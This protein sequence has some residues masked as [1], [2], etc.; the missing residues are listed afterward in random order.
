[1][2]KIINF[3]KSLFPRKNERVNLVYPVSWETMDLADFKSVCEILSYSHGREE[4]LFLCF[5]KLAN[6]RPDNPAKYDPKA[7]KDK[8]P[9]I[10]GGKSYVISS[11]VIAEGCRQ[12]DFIL[13]STGL[14]PSPF[15]NVD[16]KIFG[17]SFEKFFKTDS[18][19]MAAMVEKNAARLKEASKCLTGGRVRKL[20]PWQRKAM[21]IWWNGVKHYLKEKYPYVLQEGSGFSEKSQADILQDLLSAM[22]N[23]R[24]QENENILKCDVHS[25]LYSLNKIYEN[26]QQRLSQ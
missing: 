23:N 4:T 2:K 6:I 13:D 15:D 22:N 26:A 19:M 10:I 14:P 5:C 7:I 12:V 21:V 18:L 3:I 17:I 11:E 25:V 16:G 9:F 24:P 1:M 20:L 8:M